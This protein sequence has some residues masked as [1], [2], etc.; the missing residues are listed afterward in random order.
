[1]LISRHQRHPHAEQRERGNERRHEGACR[2]NRS[3]STASR[4]EGLRHIHPAHYAR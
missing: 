1:M 3:A 4:K 2:R